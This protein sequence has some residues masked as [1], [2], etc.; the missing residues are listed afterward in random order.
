M[1]ALY[2]DRI[3]VDEQ[4]EQ[5]LTLPFEEIEAASVL[6]RNK[7][8]LYLKDVVYQVKGEHHF[9]ALKYVNFYYRYKTLTEEN[10][11]GEFLGL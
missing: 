10:K 3:T 5:P 8:N 1:F 2:G 11:D 6:G 4:G 9:N 7:L